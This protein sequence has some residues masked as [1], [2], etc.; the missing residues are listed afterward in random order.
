M[1]NFRLGEGAAVPIL[2][3]PILA[4]LILVVSTYMERQA[5]Q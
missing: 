1:R 5:A 2:M 4:T 3:L